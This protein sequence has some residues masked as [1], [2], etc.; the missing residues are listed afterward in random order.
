MGAS[1]SDFALG[2]D[3]RPAA[4]GEFRL[5]HQR[6]MA[7]EI[8]DA[9]RTRTIWRPS[10]SVSAR[11]LQL[12]RGGLLRAGQE[13][14]VRIADANPRFSSPASPTDGA[15]DTQDRSPR[16]RAVSCVRRCM[17]RGDEQCG[18]LRTACA[19]ATTVAPRANRSACA[20]SSA[21]R[22][23]I[24]PK[25]IATRPESSTMPTALNSS[26]SRSQSPSRGVANEV[27]APATTRAV[28]HRSTTDGR[29]VPTRSRHPRRARRTWLCSSRR[30]RTRLE[31]QHRCRRERK[32]RHH[33]EACRRCG[34]RSRCARS[35]A[36]ILMVHDRTRH[37]VHRRKVEAIAFKFDPSWRCR[38]QRQP[39]ELQAPRST[40]NSAR[41]HAMQ[42]ELFH[43]SPFDIVESCCDIS[44]RGC[45]RRVRAPPIDVL[46][47]PPL[48]RTA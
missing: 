14:P 7:R 35:G 1:A 2:R 10:A 17:T 48:K 40:E 43:R 25:S 33:D 22:R 39:A 11:S 6:V 30:L 24:S 19:L 20:A 37:V 41:A 29:A 47:P 21:G 9:R 44:V 32:Q 42:F 28:A 18:V 38:L 31:R 16:P 15:R 13:A 8:G 5:E 27:A 23:S 45:G 12:P 3:D 36:S 34:A 46:L 26:F 4:I